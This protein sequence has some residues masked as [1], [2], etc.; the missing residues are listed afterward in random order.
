MILI[1]RRG[2]ETRRR[3]LLYHV[4]LFLGQ[5]FS[6]FLIR[7]NF[8]YK[9]NNQ[10][11]RTNEYFKPKSLYKYLY[12]MN[13]F[14]TKIVARE[15]INTHCQRFFRVVSGFKSLLKSL[16]YFF[17]YYYFFK[18]FLYKRTF[19]QFKCVSCARYSVKSE[20]L[21]MIHLFK[22]LNNNT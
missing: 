16:M 4:P 2:S 13:I 6:S 3:S 18:Y 15:R 20:I 21:I 17:F 7:L 22:Y 8:T 14:S 1:L 5:R 12:N 11:Q 9:A 10:S 19:I